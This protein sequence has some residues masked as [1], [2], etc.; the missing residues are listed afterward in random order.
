LC[1]KFNRQLNDRLWPH[2]HGGKNTRGEWGHMDNLAFSS[3]LLNCF[4]SFME[5]SGYDSNAVYD[6]KEFCLLLSD[7]LMEWCLQL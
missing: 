7:E 1:D 5:I 6:Y 2:K 4:K 3:I